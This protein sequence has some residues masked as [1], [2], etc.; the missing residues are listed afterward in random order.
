MQCLSSVHKVHRNRQTLE[1]ELQKGT[2]GIGLGKKRDAP[3][4]LHF[5]TEVG[6]LPALTIA[7]FCTIMAVNMLRRRME[8]DKMRE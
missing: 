8:C 6:C 1:N 3:Q 2:A 7:M 5:R 4:K